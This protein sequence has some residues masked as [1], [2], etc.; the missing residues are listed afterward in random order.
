[1]FVAHDLEMVVGADQRTAAVA[2]TVASGVEE[3][4][5]SPTWPMQG[6]VDSEEA[7]VGELVN[8]PKLAEVRMGAVRVEDSPAI[9]TLVAAVPVSV[10]ESS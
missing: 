3:A 6:M 4:E 9:T 7:E 1:M 5:E 8:S 2:S 10:V